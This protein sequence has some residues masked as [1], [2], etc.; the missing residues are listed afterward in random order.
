MSERAHEIKGFRFAGLSA[1]IKKTGLPDLALAVAEQPVSAAAVFTE[2]LVQAAPVKIA[3]QRLVGGR[4]QAALVNSGNA[5]A[6]TGAP[7]HEA[8]LKAGQAVAQ[9]LGIDDA[10]LVPASTGVIGQ[11]LPADKIVAAAP[12]LIDKL[13]ASGSGDFARA[14]MTTDKAQ[15]TAFAKLSIAGREVSLLGVAKGAGMI[16]PRMATTLGFVFSDVVIAP[17]ELQG[18]LRDA[19][20]HSFNVA[21][22]DGET[23]TND[24]ILVMASGAAG[25]AVLKA[26]SSELREFE[27]ALGAVLRE[28]AEQIVADGEGAEH[29]ADVQVRGTATDADARAIARRI[30]TSLLVK[31]AMHGKDANWGRILSAAGVAGVRFDPEVVSIAI[32]DVLIVRDGLGLGAAAEAEAQKL[33]RGPRYA[34]RVSVGSGTGQASYLT[35]DIGHRYIDVNAGYRS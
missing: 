9:A 27:Q 29:V 31:T 13:S 17:A 21:T 24:M 4:A 6:C 20:E 25:N 28:L 34:I 30:A 8:A 26:G 2:N 19:T 32:D 11:L 35:C 3:R 16:H 15:K 33:M 18:A 7:G 23:S 12:A 5:N 10:L 22:V 14:I 1:G